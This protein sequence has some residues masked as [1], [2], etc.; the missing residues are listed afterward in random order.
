MAAVTAV[1]LPDADGFL[2]NGYV[3]PYPHS[4]FDG[5]CTGQCCFPEAYPNPNVWTCMVQGCYAKLHQ[6]GEC[7]N[8]YPPVP[9]GDLR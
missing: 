4:D 7:I 5:P 9:Q 1:L 2:P 8:C 6:P 3:E